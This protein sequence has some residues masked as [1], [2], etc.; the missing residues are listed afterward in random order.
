MLKR[1]M[2]RVYLEI[3]ETGELFEISCDS[4]RVPVRGCRCVRSCFIESP[5]ASWCDRRRTVCCIYRVDIGVDGF[6]LW[7]F[8]TGRFHTAHGAEVCC[9]CDDVDMPGQNGR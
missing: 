2:T 3:S 8:E 6:N 4:K 7:L 9:R 5:Q 1:R